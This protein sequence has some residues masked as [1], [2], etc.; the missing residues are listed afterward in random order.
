[1]PEA[2]AALATLLTAERPLCARC[3]SESGVTSTD[4]VAYIKNTAGLFTLHDNIDRCPR[5]GRPAKFAAAIGSYRKSRLRRYKTQ[6][7]VHI[8]S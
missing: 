2:K 7:G 8:G 6:R 3:I 4:I 1:M 5:C